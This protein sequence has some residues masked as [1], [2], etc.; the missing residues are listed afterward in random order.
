[1]EINT[2][3]KIKHTLDW[4][5]IGIGVISLI[6][7][8]AIIGFYLNDFWYDFFSITGGI[9]LILFV[10]QEAARWLIQSKLFEYLKSRIIE[11]T[12]AGIA[13][14]T[15]IFPDSSLELISYA[16]QGLS[17]NE[18]SLFFIAL[19]QIAVILSI[20]L[21]GLRYNNLF[22]KFNF[23][24][25]AI[26]AASFLIVIIAGTLLLLMPRAVMEGKTISFTD[27]LFT[28]TS[29]VCVTGLAVVDT[30]SHFT[31]IGKII[32]ITLIQIGG[33]GLMTLTTFFAVVFAGGLSVRVKVFM[34][35]LL[36]QES[37]TEGASLLKRI[38]LF[39]FLVEY[40]GSLL[41]YLS[42]GGSLINIDKHLYYDCLFHSISA[43]CNA[44]FSIYSDG[45]MFHTI[46]SNYIYLSVIM[47]L[48]VLG[49][50][51]FYTMMDLSRNN[52]RFKN[53][54]FLKTS[55][56]LI[57]ITTLGL[58]VSGC[59]IMFIFEQNNPETSTW[60]ETV[61]HSLFLSVT[62]R[63][64]GFNTLSM[65]MVSSA[66]AMVLIIL[67]WIGASPGSTG[68]GIKT[69]TFAVMMITLLNII[70]GKDRVEVFNRE[71]APENIR[72]SS[73]VMISSLI[74]LGFGT[75]L[76]VWIEPQLNPLDLIFEATSAIATVGLSRNITTTLT[77]SSKIILTIL[78][79]VGRIGVFTFFLS[80]HKPEAEPR[81]KL[82]IE[83]IMI[84]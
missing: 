79:Y 11:N 71:I 24:S 20:L 3:N 78:M 65:S 81:Y 58:I 13:L 4:L 63:T 30:S 36:S 66:T 5:L 57:L 54:R 15:L 12:I 49:G 38:L 21:R 45:L 51:G 53:R 14:L 22:S 47:A 43:F 23:H 48:I 16:F 72:Q 60:Y 61:F 59:L 17:L 18:I 2:R 8:I 28:S 39:T 69:T 67:M 25:G 33:L 35:D 46:Q 29:A 37:M 42:L 6:S 26:I 50:L 55:T 56:K 31:G 77:D 10:L 73:M 41:L 74:F 83:K 34:K 76:L 82:P 40:I 1:M 80:L 68:G 19:S 64:A 7:F 70:R 84:G 32:I 52:F 9:T 44:G 27:A 62:A 75:T